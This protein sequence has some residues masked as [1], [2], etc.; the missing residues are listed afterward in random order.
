MDAGRA[1]D[2]LEQD[3]R[4]LVCAADTDNFLP[5]LLGGRCKKILDPVRGVPS[6]DEW[7]KAVRAFSPV[8]CPCGLWLSR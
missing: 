2:V 5:C 8:G 7:D 1:A 3:R 4:F 6:H